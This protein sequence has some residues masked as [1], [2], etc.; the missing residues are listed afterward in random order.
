M[1]CPVCQKKRLTG[2]GSFVEIPVP[3]SEQGQPDLSNPV[4]IVSIDRNSLDYNCDEEKRLR[5]DIITAIVG[6][7]EEITTR[8]ALNEQQIRANFESQSTV[9][10]RI[11]KGFEE[12]QQWVDETVCRLRYGNLFLSCSISYG[13]EFYLFSTDELR[14][15]YKTAK[16][17]GMS[18]SELDALHQQ[19]IETEYRNNPQQLQRMLILAEL[20][21]YRQLTRNEVQALYDKGLV[22]IEE[23]LVKLNFADFIRRFERENMNII[24]FGSAGAY[25]TKINTIRERLMAYAS[26][27]A[28]NVKKP[29]NNE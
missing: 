5:S 17:T 11:K 4:G 14:E 15:R 1:P 27:V 20:E 12:A 22:S 23:Y 7:N 26:E 21:P 16:E 25:D 28:P 10:N 8:D 3:N 9:L 13:T 24:E 18:E 29:I 2:A 6:T 19:I